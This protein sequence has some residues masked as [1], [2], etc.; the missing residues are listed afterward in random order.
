MQQVSRQ[1]MLAGEGGAGA[2]AEQVAEEG[3]FYNCNGGGEGS[4]GAGVIVVQA[5]IICS[6]TFTALHESAVPDFATLAGSSLPWT[7]LPR[8]PP[9]APYCSV[10]ALSSALGLFPL[11]PM[12]SPS[13]SSQCGAY[14]PSGAC[15]AIGVRQP[16]LFGAVPIRDRGTGFPHQ[17][18]AAHPISHTI[19]HTCDTAAE[20]VRRVFLIK[21]APHVYTLHTTPHASHTSHH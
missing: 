11:C 18:C 20:T 7:H 4:G 14:A 3:A 9:L 2:G 5:L 21:G 12:F 10:H 8:L 16:G 19:R 13:H 1:G 17:R 6:L 15:L